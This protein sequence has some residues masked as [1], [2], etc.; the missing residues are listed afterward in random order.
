MRCFG[1]GDPLYEA[2][3][4]DEWGRP[5]TT[6]RGLFEKV[7]LEGFQAG[8]SWSLV[9]RRRA[10]LRDAFAGFD[11]DA[12]VGWGDRQI[13]TALEAPGMI[14]SRAKV[15]MVV[16]NARA[17]VDLRDAGGLA[18]LIWSFAPPGRRAAPKRL[19]DVPAITEESA[20]MAKALKKA[21]FRFVGAT[22]CY[23]LMQADGLVNDHVAG[24]AV[25]AAVEADRRAAAR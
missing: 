2:Y 18:E 13:D 22:T 8:L 5:V 20:A 15:S 25:R 7:C 11:P 14:R 1:D 24:C 6:E 17:C 9:L 3:H 12:L 21:G 19:A 10:S 4:D 23:A 16:T